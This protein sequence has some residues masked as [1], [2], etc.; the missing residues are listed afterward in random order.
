VRNNISLAGGNADSFTGGTLSTNNSW[1]VLSPAAGTNDFLSVDA[2]F[3]AAPR[4]DDGG[5]PE[6]PFSARCRPAGWWTRGVYIG[7]LFVG[8]APDLGA[9]ETTTW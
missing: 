6:T 2:S 5:L 3:A 7:D 1:Q 8:P 4:R 9:Y